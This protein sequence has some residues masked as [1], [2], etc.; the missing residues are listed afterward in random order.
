[1]PTIHGLVTPEEARAIEG[2]GYEI[3]ILDL[4]PGASIYVHGNLVNIA[5][6]VDCDVIDLLAKEQ[7][8]A[9]IRRNRE[10]D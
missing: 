6:W 3:E 10:E 4:D 8:L 2:S 1:M 9:Q 5:V 7:I